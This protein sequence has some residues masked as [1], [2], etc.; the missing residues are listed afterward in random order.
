[1]PFLLSDEGGLAEFH[2]VRSNPIARLDG[3]AAVLA[4]TGPD[5]YVSPD[6]YGMDDQVPTWNYVAV[7]LRGRLERMPEAAMHDLLE[8]QSAEYEARLAPKPPWTMDK[9]SGAVRDRLMRAI[10]PYRLVVEGVESTWKLSQNKPAAA[11]LGA[12]E[13]LEEAGEGQE[14]AALAALMRRAEPG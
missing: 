2:L 1:V 7:H 9:T 13:G 4:V 6:W 8:R 11:R 14:T 3:V 12:A 10:L 5:G